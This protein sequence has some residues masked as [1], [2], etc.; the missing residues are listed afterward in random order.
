MSSQRN[1]FSVKILSLR[2]VKWS[3]QSKN[4]LKGV[5][6]W[7]LMKD[8]LLKH[9]THA[10]MQRARMILWVAAKMHN[11]SSDGDLHPVGRTYVR[12][13]VAIDAASAGRANERD[14]DTLSDT[15]VVDYC[16]DGDSTSPPSPS[17]AGAMSNGRTMPSTSI[18]PCP[19]WSGF[20]FVFVF[21]PPSR[22]SQ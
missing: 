2:T 1:A 9:A 13:F 16:E 20:F 22:G 3:T 15:S 6:D 10:N 12:S 19:C 11:V 18:G 21:C 17:I 4:V 14:V 8:S 7:Q 5:G